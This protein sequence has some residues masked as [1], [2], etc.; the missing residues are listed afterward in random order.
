VDELERKRGELLA[1]EANLAYWR[2]KV[3]FQKAERRRLAAEIEGQE[4]LQEQLNA[5]LER[6]NAAVMQCLIR[7]ERGFPQLQLEKSLAKDAR[8]F[9][10][11]H[12]PNNKD[13]STLYC[14]HRSTLRS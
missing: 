2:Q 7:N 12:R 14:R 11:S 6:A 8:L 9:H 13:L 10:S 1:A 5:E 3:E 4:N